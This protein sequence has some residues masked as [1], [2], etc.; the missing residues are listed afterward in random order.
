M[1][2]YDTRYVEKI[3]QDFFANGWIKDNQIDWCIY[4][5][6]KAISWCF[7]FYNDIDIYCRLKKDNGSNLLYQC[8]LS[9]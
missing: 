8:F 2:T 7:F 9:V 6:E 4:S 5:I 3:N 1:L